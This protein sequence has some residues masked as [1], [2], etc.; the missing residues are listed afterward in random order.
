[1]SDESIKKFFKDVGDFNIPNTKIVPFNLLVDKQEMTQ[2]YF[3]YSS[4]ISV[5]SAEV[6]F[7]SLNMYSNF[8]LD[9][10]MTKQAATQYIDQYINDNINKF[11]SIRDNIVQILFSLPFQEE[12]AEEL[13]EIASAA[14]ESIGKWLRDEYNSI[15]NFY[16]ENS[17]IIERANNLFIEIVLESQTQENINNIFGIKANPKNLQQLSFLGKSLTDILDPESEFFTH[18]KTSTILLNEKYYFVGTPTVEG[19]PS[20][21]VSIPDLESFVSSNPSLSGTDV[22]E[23]WPD[24]WQPAIR[25]SSFGFLH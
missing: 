10:S 17:S 6:M 2:K 21:V 13:T 3:Y 14:N 5:L 7:K 9:T 18:P 8:A 24:G 20:G 16:S 1:L 23:I 19:Y 22:S 12:Y 15:D 25:I 4:L 11:P